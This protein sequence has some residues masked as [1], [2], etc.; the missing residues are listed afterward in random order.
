[1]A[2][3]RPAVNSLDCRIAAKQNRTLR[4]SLPFMGAS[5]RLTVSIRSSQ[6]NLWFASAR[7]H[8]AFAVSNLASICAIS[9]RFA[10]PLSGGSGIAGWA[11]CRFGGSL[12][13]GAF[14]PS[15]SALISNPAR[16]LTR[17]EVADARGTFSCIQDVPSAVRYLLRDLA[18]ILLWLLKKIQ[19]RR[20]QTSS[21]PSLGN[22]VEQ[23]DDWRRRG[24]DGRG[25]FNA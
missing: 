18:G 3:A 14:Q 6:L 19:I 22:S 25:A 21:S 8:R 20:S 4:G 24:D 7:I 23:I 15:F 9:A 10:S 13:F 2:M 1:V 5:F 12:A 17:C 11:F 16:F